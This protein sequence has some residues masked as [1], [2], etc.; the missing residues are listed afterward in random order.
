[1]GTRIAF[2]LLLLGISFAGKG[3]AQENVC[4]WEPSFGLNDKHRKTDIHDKKEKTVE[5]EETGTTEESVNLEGTVK[6]GIIGN[7]EIPGAVHPDEDDGNPGDIFLWEFEDE[8]VEVP[9]EVDVSPDE[10]GGKPGDKILWEFEE[11]EVEVPEEMDVSPD[12]DGGKPGDKILWEFE[13]EEVEV[14][15]EMDVS[16]DEED[17]KPADNFLWEFVEDEA[18]VPEE[19]DVDPGKSEIG[20]RT[21]QGGEGETG[22][23]RREEAAEEY[24]PENNGRP[25]NGREGEEGAGESIPVRIGGHYKLGTTWNFNRESPNDGER[26]R[27]GLSSLEAELGLELDMRLGGWKLF[28]SG[29]GLYD[30]AFGINGRGDYTDEVLDDYEK[31]LELREAWGQGSIGESLDLK[32]GRQITV[33]G[34]SDNFR[35]TDLLNPLDNRE[36]GLTDIEDLRMPAAMTKADYYMGDW[37]L[38]L[39]A[40]HEHR[41]DKNPPFGHDF[42][43][44]KTAPP[45][46]SEPARTLSNTGLAACLEWVSG[47]RDLSFYW[48]STYDDAVTFT[49]TQ[50]PRGEHRR[51]KT[52]GVAGSW[53]VGDFLLIGEAAHTRGLRYMNDY[54]KTYSRTDLLAGMEYRGFTD[55]VISLDMMNRRLHGYGDHLSDSPE[56]P[57]RNDFQAALRIT[58][59]LMNEELE[60][61]ALL[62]S[63]G[64]K[65]E[66]GGF[67]RFTAKYRINDDWRVTGN[68]VFYQSGTGVMENAGDN[69]RFALEICRGF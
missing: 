18:E 44:G 39:I 15:E 33:W 65:A 58:R 62:V 37:K 42:F 11:E 56:F 46:D 34:R 7:S 45:R 67:Q 48:A 64:V 29:R 20:E 25:L 5:K 4:E 30:T 22:G 61:T 54:G 3:I 35:V 8:E 57:L 14:P 50:P 27:R 10:D 2:C 16:P 24:I 32:L 59:N 51:I 19:M 1:M 17:G 43:P 41:F 31:A 52:V 9:G 40:L 66:H 53:A 68:L 38:S 55:T 6:V 36:P 63:M 12:E 26:D 49:P 28:V 21:E 47:N 69:D 60:L 23:E 13:E